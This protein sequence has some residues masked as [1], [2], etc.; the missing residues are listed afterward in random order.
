MIEFW[1]DIYQSDDYI[2]L[3]LNSGDEI[4]RFCYREADA[5]FQNVS[6]KSKIERIGSKSVSGYYHLESVYGYGGFYTN[7]QDKDFIKRALESYKK[8]CENECII[9]EFMRFN[10]FN[11]FCKSHSEFFDVC[12]NN[13]ETVLVNLSQSYD[14]IFNSFEPSLRRNVRSA[15][16]HELEFCEIELNCK[17]AYKFYELYT[18]TMTK[19][20]AMKFYFFDESYFWQLFT[21]ENVK[22]YGA[23]F[24]G[25]I[26]NMIVLFM[27]KGVIYYHLG[28]SDVRFYNLNANAFVFDSIIKTYAKTQNFLYLGGGTSSD[29]N[30]ALFK[31]KRKFSKDIRQFYIAG[32]IYN[33]KIYN[34]YNEIWQSQS[35]KTSKLFLKYTDTI[36]EIEN[37]GTNGGG[38]G[39]KKKKR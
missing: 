34:L 13:R 30:D 31:F 7:T 23:K 4:F 14:E 2:R 35:S 15:I 25:E 6:I 19:N 39:L 27:Q 3:Y 8:R 38:D 9:A 12:I 32:L 10:V 37:E 1:R 11:D 28:A 22:V 29:S 33:H 26:V 16:K 18:Q 21:L 36:E 17:N 24:R 20:N 5:I